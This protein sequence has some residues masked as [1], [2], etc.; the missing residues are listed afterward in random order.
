MNARKGKKFAPL[1]ANATQ[2][3]KKN[4]RRKCA[5]S[6]SNPAMQQRNTAMQQGNGE[7]SRPQRLYVQGS[8]TFPS[9][10]PKRMGIIHKNKLLEPSDAFLSLSQRHQ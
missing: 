7:I 5:C 2:K 9:H 3:E 8:C 6:S 1:F 4:G 10:K